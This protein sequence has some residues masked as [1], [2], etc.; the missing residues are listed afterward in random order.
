[1]RIAVVNWTRQVVG[2]AESYLAGVLPALAARGHTVALVHE[3]PGAEDRALI[4]D[5]SMPSWCVHGQPEHLAESLRAWHPDVIWAHVVHDPAMELALQGVAPAVL[6]AH[7]YYGTC[8][9]GLKTHQS[10]PKP[11][12]RP[13]GPGCLLHYYPHRC[14]GL[15]PVTML[16]DYRTQSR[17]REL[18]GGYRAIM[19]ASAHMREEYLRH[20]LPPA[21]VLA[22]P[23]FAPV[24]EDIL[25]DGVLPTTRPRDDGR[26]R[27]LFTGRMDALKG[28]ALLLSCLLTVRHRLGTRLSVVFAGEGPERD[29]WEH[30]AKILMRA[31]PLLTISFPGWQRGE[32]LQQLW[33]ESD[34][35][36]V[37]SVWPEPFGL[38]GPEA[39]AFGLP[40]A[41]FDVG[42]I[43]EWLSDG[44]NG[45]LA[46]G[47]R[48][49]AVRLTDAIVR[50]L[51]EP[52]HHSALRAGASRMARRFRLAPHLAAVEQILTT[53][54]ADAPGRGRRAPA[55]A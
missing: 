16:R 24:V 9:S 51:E 6:F 20:G 10:V 45:H 34:L 31:D 44:V 17:R 12:G 49:D 32:A 22:P 54:A 50:C 27:L 23:F 37:P 8:I 13:L 41:A 26:M 30:Q 14:G 25:A 21:L 28:G 42:G 47:D 2:G 4:G 18:L 40:V 36:V 43:R 39:G 48:P 1:M 3:Q 29:T 19:T 46:P 7:G 5:A 38:V 33:R 11:C 15:S 55:R 53:A 35:L 52:D